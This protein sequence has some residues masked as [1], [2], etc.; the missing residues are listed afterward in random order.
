MSK[1]PDTNAFFDRAFKDHQIQK[2]YLA[3]TTQPP[4]LF[5]K[6]HSPLHILN[7]SNHW[8]DFIK[9]YI[10]ST[11]FEL[12]TQHPSSKVSSQSSPL[13]YDLKTTLRPDPQSSKKQTRW[14]VGQV[15][16]STEERSIDLKN[17]H[18][19]F[20]SFALLAQYTPRHGPPLW[21][22][23]VRLHTG[24]T[25]QIRAHLAHLKAPLVGDLL[26]GGI[27]PWPFFGLHARSVLSPH[28]KTQSPLLHFA[29][30]PD[31][32]HQI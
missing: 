26:Y 10:N 21:V 12:S 17:K 29:L 15:F 13:W 7:T 19:A 22:S 32:W 8:T 14:Q 20:S 1:H 25:H 18:Y 9:T 16:A 28:P 23:E 24:R 6:D 5:P 2:R 3:L 4:S 11:H 27:S 31:T 30:L